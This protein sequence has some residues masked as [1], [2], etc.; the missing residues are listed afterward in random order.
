MR[1]T[2]RALRAISN[3]NVPSTAHSLQEDSE[4]LA[5]FFYRNKH[6]EQWGGKSAVRMTL[7]QLILYGQSARRNSQLLMESA[8]FVRTELATRMAHRI[9][10]LQ[11]LPMVVMSNQK[12]DDI[13]QHYWRTFE[14][15]RQLNRIETTEQNEQLVQQLS[16]IL[17]GL[18]NKLSLLVSISQESSLYMRQSAVDVFI[19][20]MLRSQ[21]SREILARQHMA[22]WAMQS[23]DASMAMSSTIGVINTRL[24]VSELL[25]KS[26]YNAT[27]LVAHDNGWSEDD[28]RLPKVTFDGDLDVRMAYLPVHLEFITTELIKLALQATVR[29]KSNKPVSVTIVGGHNVP[30][31]IIRVSDQGGG[32]GETSVYHSGMPAVFARGPFL[33]PG[34]NHSATL[35]PIWSFANIARQLESES[36]DSAQAKRA[37]RIEHITRHSSDELASDSLAAARESDALMRL[38]TINHDA[39]SSLPIVRLYAEIFGGSLEYRTM[40]GYGTDFYLRL[41]MFGT[42]QELHE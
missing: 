13:Y 14:S 39:R 25:R 3:A 27:S 15:L 41:P 19:G 6:V 7:R 10:D 30:D 22:L 24:D 31:L 16:L 28:D 40:N 37:E 1:Q 4:A 21:I 26:A 29:T 20:R 35:D 17:S 2:L 5:R 42:S 8:N 38:T 9:R 23:D 33:L 36:F 12:L 32:L 34:S 18:D 11:T